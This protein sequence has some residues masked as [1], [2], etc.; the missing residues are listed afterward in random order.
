M[1][2][3]KKVEETET[4]IEAET[5]I[6]PTKKVEVPK[7]NAKVIATFTDIVKGERVLPDSEIY[8]SSDRLE[9][10]EKAGCVI[11]L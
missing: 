9:F 6:T 4:K 10:L 3:P 11:R 5:E 8:L 2:K 7:A 1:S